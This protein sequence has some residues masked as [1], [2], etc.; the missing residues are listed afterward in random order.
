MVKGISLNEI[1]ELIKDFN[2]EEK[3]SETKRNSIKIFKHK[4]KNGFRYKFQYISPIIKSENIIKLTDKSQK[5]EIPVYTIL[6]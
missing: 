3:S 1:D 4:K 6:N 2:S 5:G